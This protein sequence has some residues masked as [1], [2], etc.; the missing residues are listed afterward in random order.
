VRAFWTSRTG[1]NSLAPFDS[2]NL[3]EHCD[4]DPARVAANRRRLSEWLAAGG[5]ARHELDPEPKWL[6]Q[7]HG[8]RVV[9]LDEWQPGI[10]ADAAW[11]D[12]PGRIAAILTADCLPIL[13]ADVR[14]RCIAAVHAGWRGLA[15]GVIEQT[16]ASLPVRPDEL[17]AWIGPAI[18]QSNYEVGDEVREVFAEH[19][20]AF[21]RSG[22]KRWL[23]DLPAIASALMEA[24][25][26]TRIVDS[27]LCTASDASRFFSHR[28]DGATGRMACLIWLD[29]DGATNDKVG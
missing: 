1:G 6:R 14:G 23:A 12:R 4:D 2:L 28:R 3:G 19:P 15:A 13:I 25:G 10:E 7:V 18:R 20:A 27:G 16:L 8:T 21:R 5:Q 9:H 17:M 11:T 24:R 26:L 22:G 29:R